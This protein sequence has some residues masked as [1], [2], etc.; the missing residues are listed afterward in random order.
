MTTGVYWFYQPKKDRVIY[1]GSSNNIE[2]RIKRHINGLKRGK[3]INPI[4]QNTWNKHGQSEF[5]ATLLEETDLVHLIERE[6]FWMDFF[7]PTCNIAIAADNPM[8][9]RKFSEETR[10]KL[11]KVHLGKKHSEEARQKMSNAQR[12]KKLSKEHKQKLSEANL[13]QKRG[14]MSEEQKR[15]LSESHLGHKAS[16]ETRKKMGKAQLGRKHSE[17]TRQKLSKYHLGC[18]HSEETRQKISATKKLR[19]LLKRQETTNER[20]SSGT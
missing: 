2:K 16:E 8:R 7:K 3:H 20:H 14:P 18:K 4:F 12:G 1:I 6:Q 19:N 5:E 10:R 9:G 17:E 15:K 11:S 13:G